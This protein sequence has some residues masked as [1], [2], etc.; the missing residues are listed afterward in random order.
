MKQHGFAG[1]QSSAANIVDRKAFL[2]FL[3]AFVLE[4]F[5]KHGLAGCFGGGKEQ[6]HNNEREWGR[7]S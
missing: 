2:M 5:D 3:E 1:R 6:N 4:T 7:T